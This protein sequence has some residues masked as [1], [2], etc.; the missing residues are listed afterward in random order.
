[1]V[2]VFQS[3]LLLA[4]SLSTTLAADDSTTVVQILNGHY[5]TLA[6]DELRGSVVG[7]DAQATTYAVN[8]KEGSSSC[9]L[10][11]PITI[12]QGPSTFT[13]SA[14]YTMTTMGAKGTGTIVQDC[15]ITSSTA[16]AVCSVSVGAKVEYKGQSTSTSFATTA[17][18]TG[19]AEVLYEPLTVTAGLGNFNKAGPTGAAATGAAADNNP[20]LARDTPQ[21]VLNL[22]CKMMVDSTKLLADD[23][24]EL[25]DLAPTRKRHGTWASTKSWYSRT[26]LRSGKGYNRLPVKAQDPNHFHGW[27]FGALASCILV[28]ICLGLNVAAT[29]YV[30]VTYP[31]SSDNLGIMQENDCNHIHSVDSRLHYALNVIATVLVSASNYNMQCLTAPTR[32]EVDQAHARRRWLDIGV[33]SMRN[34]SFVKRAKLGL[35]L[36][37]LVSTLPLHLLWNSAVV[38]T[39][40]FNDY[41]GLVVT[42]DFLEGHTDIGL[43]CTSPAMEEYRNSNLSS[44]VTCW[45]FDQA[46]NNRSSLT[47]MDPTR[48]IST[49]QAGLEGRSFNM[50][51]VT[52]Q[53][54]ALNQSKTFP[55][56]R[57][58]TLPVLAYFHPL[59]YP[60]QIEQ[61]CS[62]MCQ[63]WGKGNNSTKFCFDENWDEASVPFACQEHKVNG[64]DWEP[65][66]LSQTSSWMC[67]PDA[68]LYGQCSGSAATT[69][70]TK[71]TIL[72]E[73]YEIDHCLVTDANHT[74]QLLY[75]P[76][77]L[78]IAIA[79]NAMKFSSILLCLLVSREPTLATI[80]DALDS[81]LRSPDMVSKGQCLLS[82][83][84]DTIF[85]D[86][87]DIG[88][89]P[90][91]RWQH[92]EGLVFLFKGINLV[93]AQNAFTMGFGAL[94]LNAIV[95]TSG[96]RG[97]TAAS[98]VTTSIVANL[99]QLLLSGLYFM[100]N[101]VLTGMASAYEW[102]MFAYQQTTLRVTLPWG[103]QRETYWL[104]LPWRYSL[105][106]LAC[107]TIIHWLISQSI[108]L[109]NLKIY[110]PNNEL[111]TRPNTHFPSASDSGVI[112]ACGYSPLA[113]ITALAVA[114]LMFAVLTTVS[115]FKLKPDIPV[116]GSC[117]VAISAAC[118]PPE[119]DSD[120]A[121]KPLS[122]GA[123]R[124]QEGDRPGH[125][126]LTS[127]AVE[128]PRYGELYAG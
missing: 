65:N 27:R 87:D 19:S 6:F 5:N 4:A 114:I 51:A 102:S 127:Q 18:A 26:V 48:C 29:I 47:Q 97:G 44:Y 105:P 126:C 72:P 62:G 80:G 73:H 117:S 85:T 123:V 42:Q 50:L 35:W 68:I 104:Q 99:P 88:S 46:R 23:A 125:C 43:D 119:E 75:S 40:T 55:P 21:S 91:Q 39:T 118:H 122:W 108:F 83:M 128:K 24:V 84:D 82:K 13:M 94:S 11:K 30:R 115:T 16:T 113:I 69:N 53:S 8:C 111:L 70:A 100:Y 15:D 74:C 124:H 14:I 10:T 59:D 86:P 60:D 98:I 95:S 121:G 103:A 101:A 93:G 17:T 37:L 9:P 63:R 57:N 109:I 3:L 107:S 89:A 64:T 25:P 33:H 32:D 31:P 49:Y 120:A 90:A 106:L 77:I 1:M 92:G 12:T 110:Q 61:W 67:H 34:L 54:D 52:K 20:A 28:G 56:P 45:L 38:M 58:T 112:T 71:W 66:A 2:R 22:N 36:A 79:C 78:Y 76:I 81:F 7:G 96:Y 116:V 41:S